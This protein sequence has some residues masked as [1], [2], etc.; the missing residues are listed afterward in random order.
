MFMLIVD[1]NNSTSESA[2]WVNKSPQTA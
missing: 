2:R 1:P